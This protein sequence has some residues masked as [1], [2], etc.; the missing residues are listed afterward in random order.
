MPKHPTHSKRMSSPKASKSLRPTTERPIV[1]IENREC[2]RTGQTSVLIRFISRAGGTKDLVISSACFADKRL[3]TQALLNEG[4]KL[5][6]DFKAARAVVS[7]C[8]TVWPDKYVRFESK[9]GWQGENDSMYCVLPGRKI[10]LKE[11]LYLRYGDPGQ[12]SSAKINREHKGTLG[13]YLT[14]IRPFMTISD[15][16]IYA[17]ALGFSGTTLFMSPTPESAITSFF[18]QTSTGK[19]TLLRCTAGVF[20]SSAAGSVR[21]FDLTGTALEELAGGTFNDRP[22]PIDELVTLLGSA[23]GTQLST[24]KQ[25]I[26]KLS[27]GQGRSRSHR[28][29]TSGLPRQ[30]WRTVLVTTAEQSFRIQLRRSGK[31]LPEGIDTR[32]IEIPVPDVSEG[33]I[34]NKATPGSAAT[35]ADELSEVLENHYGVAELAFVKFIESDRAGAKAT[36]KEAWDSFLATH[37]PRLTGAE[38][39]I[40]K[41]FA[42]VFASGSLAVA[43]GAAPFELDDLER[44]CATLQKLALKPF[45]TQA[46]R[47]TNIADA[48]LKAAR[49]RGNKAIFTSSLKGRKVLCVACSKDVSEV[50]SN[51]DLQFLIAT[52][53]DLGKA[54]TDENRKDTKVQLPSRTRLR[55][56]A[57]RLSWLQTLSPNH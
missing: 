24:L 18:G 57:F 25:M 30:T 28:A 44:A 29:E 27:G 5:P 31:A 39:R 3:A 20:M 53:A 15:F 16:V 19:T 54:F 9:P 8:L 40:A 51:D 11:N 1:P 49:D 2:G 6:T 42:H 14:A 48:L 26:F 13:D 43:A 34:F 41:K 7:S 50:V 45:E 4:A 32:F 55:A 17:V 12:S 35:A 21:S 22:L 52:A 10:K 47:L 33:G 56:Y 36:F 46:A 37:A 23:G 38:K